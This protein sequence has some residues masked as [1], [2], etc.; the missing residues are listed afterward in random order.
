MVSSFV[1]TLPLH[2]P[3]PFSKLTHCPQL[4]EISFINTSLPVASPCTIRGLVG[5]DKPKED[6]N[7]EKMLSVFNCLWEFL[8]SWQAETFWL[9]NVLVLEKRSVSV[10][11]ASSQTLLQTLIPF[12]H[13]LPSFII[14]SQLYAD[15]FWKKKEK[16][17]SN[18]LWTSYVKFIMFCGLECET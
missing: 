7:W 9:I 14:A 13:V 6:R 15:L 5:Q 2:P 4:Q 1:S 18:S 10:V 3:S 8:R 11:T 17:S 16:L 12:P